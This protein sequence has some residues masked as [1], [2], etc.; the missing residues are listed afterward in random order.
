MT[1]LLRL[2]QPCQD[3]YRTKLPAFSGIKSVTPHSQGKHIPVGSRKPALTLRSLAVP[4]TAPPVIEK[5]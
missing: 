3:S 5:R 2:V 1:V 4:H